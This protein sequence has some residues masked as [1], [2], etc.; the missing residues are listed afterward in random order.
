MDFSLA[1]LQARDVIVNTGMG[2]IG[3]AIAVW[4]AGFVVALKQNPEWRALW[5]A[6]PAYIIAI[7]IIYEVD[8][9][10]PWL[11]AAMQIPSAILIHLFLLYS[12]RKA[13]I[14]DDEIPEGIRLENS[15][16]RVGLFPLGMILILLLG[17]MF[18]RAITEILGYR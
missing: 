11:T 16:W 13:W 15:D 6:A 7:L 17:G 8:A 3:M 9:Y 4:L 18:G 2:F 5:T 14:D 1:D 12:Y 10:P